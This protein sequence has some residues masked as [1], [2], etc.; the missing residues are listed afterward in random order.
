MISAALRDSQ[1]YFYFLCADKQQWLKWQ[2][3]AQ[4]EGNQH[5]AVTLTDAIPV[6]R[7]PSFSGLGLLLYRRKVESQP[8]LLS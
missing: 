5:A 4:S 6:H 1:G 8:V 2:T 7:V 3:T